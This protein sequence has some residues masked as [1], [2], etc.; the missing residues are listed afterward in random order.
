MFNGSQGDFIKISLANPSVIN[1][2]PDYM[3][4]IAPS[5]I[6]NDTFGYVTK[7]GYIDEIATNGFGNGAIL[8]FDSNSSNAS[9]GYT[10]IKPVAPNAKIQLAA[11]VKA[12]SNPSAENGRLLVRVATGSTLGGTDSNVEFTNV[13]NNEVLAFNGTANRWENKTPQSLGLN[14]VLTNIA[15]DQYLAYSNG[16]WINRDLNAVTTTQITN[17]DSTYNIVNTTS[18]NWDNAFSWGNHQAVG[19]VVGS[20]N[21]SITSENI[22]VYNGTTG[23]LIKDGGVAISTVATTSY[24]DGLIGDIETILDD[25]IG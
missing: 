23:L 3:L 1:N 6:T 19:Y 25:I 14:V 7:F 13:A 20:T 17:W 16:S 11:V 18:G 2:N 8:W 5:N 4:G 15:N 22:A 10:N 21:P 12:S 24:V 9:G